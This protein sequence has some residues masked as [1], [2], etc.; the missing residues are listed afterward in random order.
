MTDRTRLIVVHDTGPDRDLA[1]RVYP[2]RAVRPHE[3]VVVDGGVL[4]TTVP[5]QADHV[6]GC[7]VLVPTA[8]RIR[9]AYQLP[10]HP[11]C[12]HIECFGDY[13]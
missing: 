5:D 12:P 13:R 8:S 7:G 9:P 6:T 2:F 4:H 10:G 1:P 3:P 11:L